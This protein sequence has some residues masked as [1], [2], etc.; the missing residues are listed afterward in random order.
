MTQATLSIPEIDESQRTPLVQEL[1]NI[2]DK[3][4]QTIAELQAKVAKLE[5]EVRRLKELPK[6][7]VIK[8]STLEQPAPADSQLS[9]QP[10]KPAEQDIREHAQRRKVSGTT[11]SDEG[12]K[13]RDKFL[14]LVKT[15]RKLGVSFQA[16]LKDR[17]RGEGKIPRLQELIHQKAKEKAKPE[18]AD[19]SADGHSSK[20]VPEDQPSV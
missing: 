9:S 20:A 14:S 16:Y 7:P 10:A 13:C 5:E 18:Q 2:I 3:Q 12:R 8:P 6:K 19:G 17:L 11:R 15:C 1:L 4:N